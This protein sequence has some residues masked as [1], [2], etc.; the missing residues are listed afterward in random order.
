MIIK[1]S[2]PALIT[3]FKDKEVDYHSF[4]KIIEWSLKEGSHGFV[5]C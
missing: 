3:P 2:I 5:P 1:G 4:E